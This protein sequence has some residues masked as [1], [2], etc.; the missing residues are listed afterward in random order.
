M[1]GHHINK[2]HYIEHN[3]GEDTTAL[4][5]K[6]NLKQLVFIGNPFFVN[7]KT[8]YNKKVESTCCVAIF[9]VGAFMLCCNVETY[10]ANE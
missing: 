5:M 10:G 7:N 2:A 3:S 8:L 1:Q 4:A 9:G 6:I